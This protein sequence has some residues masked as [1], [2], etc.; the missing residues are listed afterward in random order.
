MENELEYIDDYIDLTSIAR[1]SSCFVFDFSHHIFS[2]HHV[3]E[4]VWTS[5]FYDTPWQGCSSGP[6]AS[7]LTTVSMIEL[8]NCNCSKASSTRR[9]WYMFSGCV[10]HARR[11]LE[12][13]TLIQ[14][15]WSKLNRRSLAGF[16]SGIDCKKACISTRKVKGKDPGNE[17]EKNKVL[18]LLYRSC[19]ACVCAFVNG[20]IDSVSTSKW[21]LLVQQMAK[22]MSFILINK[23]L[24]TSN[25]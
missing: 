6:Q 25:V 9:Q 2:S 17:V 15:L 7:F 21:A 22:Y 4:R 12:A 23:H 8:S 5:S 19:L 24:K 11:L 10:L 1:S 16:H 3:S 20:S 14:P 13:I 18:K